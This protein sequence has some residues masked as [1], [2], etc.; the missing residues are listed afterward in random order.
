VAWIRER[1]AKLDR[2][3]AEQAR[4]FLSRDGRAVVNSRLRKYAG[5]DPSRV[6][7][8]WVA[9]VC[10]TE[11]LL[12]E[13]PAALRV[14]YEE[15]ATDPV[16]TARRVCEALGLC[17]EPEMLR[18]EAHAHHPLGGNTGTQSVVARAH[19]VRA[20]L[21]EVPARSRSFYQELRGGF[22][23][24]LR[25]R[26]ELSSSVLALFEE[27]AGAVNEPYRWDADEAAQARPGEPR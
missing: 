21:A 16:A 27:R 3:G 15:L 25:W 20:S 24:D 18:Y 26:T 8:A 23:L 14:R 11:A 12:E 17:F 1:A 2:A 9:S 22:A 4:I 10:A 7:D 19:Q 5:E 6:I 13:R